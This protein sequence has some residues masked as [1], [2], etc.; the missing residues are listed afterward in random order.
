M[1]TA[2]MSPRSFLLCTS[3]SCCT[4]CSGHSTNLSEF[5][6]CLDN[7]FRHILGFL[8]YPGQGQ[9]LDMVIMM[10]PLNSAY[11]MIPGFC[12]FK[13]AVPPAAHAWP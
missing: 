3:G 2:Q 11:S 4:V 7:A 1:G 6:K 12:D 8:G 10:G 5:T 9:E 13:L